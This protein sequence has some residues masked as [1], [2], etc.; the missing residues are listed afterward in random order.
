MVNKISG[1]IPAFKSYFKEAEFNVTV[2]AGVKPSDVMKTTGLKSVGLVSR[3]LTVFSSQ[4]VPISI[5]GRTH[6]YPKNEL[7]LAAARQAYRS[8]VAMVRFDEL[9]PVADH[10]YAIAKK[11]ADKKREVVVSLILDRATQKIAREH[12]I[13]KVARQEATRAMP[14]DDEMHSFLVEKAYRDEIEK[15][16]NMPDDSR[17]QIVLDNKTID[18]A[19]ERYNHVEEGSPEYNQLIDRME[20]LRNDDEKFVEKIVK[21]GVSPQFVAF[22]FQRQLENI[23]RYLKP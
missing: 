4:N 12:A 3:L 14:Y 10:K 15:L 13:E 20:S 22:H 7:E 16:A 11:L 9:P 19:C 21:A 8:Q 2:P 5:E 17:N 1:F 6:Y 18:E 23:S